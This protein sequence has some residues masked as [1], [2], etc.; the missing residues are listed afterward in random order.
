[1]IPAE[2]GRRHGFPSVQL[3]I[4]GLV[5]VVLG[6]WTLLSQVGSPRKQG[7]RPGGSM[8]T[9]IVISG[10]SIHF[11][12]KRSV[13]TACT[14]ANTTCYF[15]PFNR[16]DKRNTKKYQFFT[17]HDLNA[18]PVA[19]PTKGW[20]IDVVDT[21]PDTHTKHEVLVCAESSDYKSCS[22][23]AFSSDNIYVI[24]VGGTF[25]MKPAGP[26]TR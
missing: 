16:T 12:A 15:A 13:W 14:G 10:G 8:D 9:P 17:D 21:N 26:P 20:E 11:K 6:G 22:T 7:G 24:A 25:E 18:V 2:N 1:M 4:A 19:D 5:M 3:V 23:G